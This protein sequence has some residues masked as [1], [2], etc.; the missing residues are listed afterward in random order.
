MN[1]APSGAVIIVGADLCLL[2]YVYRF[3]MQPSL[4][5]HGH[6]KTSIHLRVCLAVFLGMILKVQVSVGRRLS[7]TEFK[8]H[9]VCRPHCLRGT[10][11]NG[12]RTVTVL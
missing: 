3:I 11:R 1:S 12:A 2:M 4:V 7:E 5:T 8:G 6:M 9:Y 10:I